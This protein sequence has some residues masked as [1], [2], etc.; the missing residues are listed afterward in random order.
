MRTCMHT[1]AFISQKGGAGK[2]TLTVNTAVA[3]QQAGQPAVIID[4]DP[5]ASASA[6]PAG[7]LLRPRTLPIS[8]RPS[9]PPSRGPGAH[10]LPVLAL[11][12]PRS[13]CLPRHCCPRR[14]PSAAV[15]SAAPPRSRLADQGI[16]L[17]PPAIAQPMAHVRAIPT[18]LSLLEAEPHSK[19]AAEIPA[20][21][22]WIEERRAKP[23]GP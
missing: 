21:Q 20:L 11:R 19:A 7:P 18:G 22:A 2:T 6:W 8:T 4:L 3:F 17:A 1:L 23:G 5:Q 12:H 14:L 16:Q 9:R 15:M 13:R 10:S